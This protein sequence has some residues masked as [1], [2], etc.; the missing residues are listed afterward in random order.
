MDDSTR[1]AAEGR[2]LAIAMLRE[3]RELQP[4]DGSCEDFFR[5]GRMQRDILNPYLEQLIASS[6]AVRAGFCTVMNDFLA[7]RED[8][9]TDIEHY[10]TLEAE[11]YDRNEPYFPRPRAA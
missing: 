1:S 3:Y 2:K 11:G 9:A 6:R 7:T 5:P 8:I 10:E 4:E